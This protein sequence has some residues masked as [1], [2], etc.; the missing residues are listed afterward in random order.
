MNAKPL[1]GVGNK[2]NRFR[3]DFHRPGTTPNL[4]IKFQDVENRR[5]IN[6]FDAQAPKLICSNFGRLNIGPAP[7]Y[8]G[9]T[10]KTPL[11]ASKPVGCAKPNL[12]VI[13]IGPI[14]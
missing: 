8:G 1:W 3:A 11:T 12:S 9:Q 5:G 2:K 14:I 6:F 10:V 7:K 13:L 4:G